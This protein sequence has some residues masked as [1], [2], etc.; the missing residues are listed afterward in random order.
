MTEHT[1]LIPSWYH[2]ILTPQ[3]CLYM[4]ELFDGLSYVQIAERHDVLPSTVSRTLIRAKRR[5]EAYRKEMMPHIVG[6]KVNGEPIY[7]DT[8][9]VVISG[10]EN[11]GQS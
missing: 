2:E 3:Q 6:I 7:S 8:D 11:I 5:I 9:S 10:G 4:Q 1:Y